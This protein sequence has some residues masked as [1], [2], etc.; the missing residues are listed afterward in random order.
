[1]DLERLAS[2]QLWLERTG[3]L[4]SIRTSGRPLTSS[5]RSARPFGLAGT[6][7]ELLGDDKAVLLDVFEVDQADGDMLA[8]RAEE[9]GAFAEHPGGEFLVPF[10]SPS[11]RAS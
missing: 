9:H 7:G 4:A 11:E 6:E 5:T 10:T 1:M 2:S 8:V 3:V